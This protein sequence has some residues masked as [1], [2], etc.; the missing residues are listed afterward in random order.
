VIISAKWITEGVTMYTAV[1]IEKDHP[2][3]YAVE[4]DDLLH[5]NFSQ[6]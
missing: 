1:L 3:S 2:T 5:Y 4:S 6:L